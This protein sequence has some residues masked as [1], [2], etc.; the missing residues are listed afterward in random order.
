[1]VEGPGETVTAPAGAELGPWSIVV[2]QIATRVG[3]VP[4]PSIPP[5]PVL[6]LEA[7]AAPPPPAPV[8]PPPLQA[9]RTR[10]P[11]LMHKPAAARDIKEL[12]MGDSIARAPQR[13]Q[14]QRRTSIGRAARSYSFIAA[15]AAT[16]RCASS[17]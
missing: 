1:M 2:S 5:L 16:T 7:L 11:R 14:A 12:V 10:A 13:R 6:P 4:P 17:T 8:P 15:S 3:P 9:T